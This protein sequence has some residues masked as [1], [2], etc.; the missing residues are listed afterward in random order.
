MPSGRTKKSPNSGRGLSHVTPK[1]FGIWIWSNISPKLIELDFKFGTRLCTENDKQAHKITPKSGRGLGH[2]TPTIFGSTVGYPSDS[3]ASCFSGCVEKLRL[4]NSTYTLSRRRRLWS[5]S[6]SAQGAAVTP[7]RYGVW[8]MS[9]WHIMGDKVATQ[10][11]CTVKRQQLVLLN[12]INI[13]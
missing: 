10:I 12:K 7:G 9:A 8:G 1:I 13:N 4:Q 5:S 3:L 11:L 2:V 6:S